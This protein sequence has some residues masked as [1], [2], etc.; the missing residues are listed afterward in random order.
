M[1]LVNDFQCSYPIMIYGT[2]DTRMSKYNSIFVKID[3]N[4]ILEL[5]NGNIIL[6]ISIRQKRNKNYKT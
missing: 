1:N 4:T 2:I 5:T 3:F 6:N